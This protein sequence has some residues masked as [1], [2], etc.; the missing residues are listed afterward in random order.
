MKDEAAIKTHWATRMVDGMGLLIRLRKR[1]RLRKI[2]ADQF[3]SI[4][5]CEFGKE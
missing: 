3:V 4:G 5:A 1:E 2:Q